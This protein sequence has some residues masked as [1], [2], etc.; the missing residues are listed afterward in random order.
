M[1]TKEKLSTLIQRLSER[2]K[3]GEISWERTI[4]PSVFQTAFPNFVI[5][6]AN[7]P[8]YG[9]Y[10]L[11]VI[12]ETGAVLES[13]NNEEL[14]EAMYPV[15]SSEAMSDLYTMARRNALDVDHALDSLLSEV[16]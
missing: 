10:D 8:R 1:G 9:V 5:T 14:S 12:D 15:Q 11:S 6:I 7:H 2:T 3:A 4:E 16:G 13:A